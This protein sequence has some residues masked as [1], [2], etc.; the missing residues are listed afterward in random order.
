MSFQTT[1]APSAARRHGMKQSHKWA[2]GRSLRK[3]PLL[4][5]CSSR[6]PGDMPVCSISPRNTQAVLCTGDA[7]AATGVGLSVS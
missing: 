3:M 1:S 6:A 2:L 5:K 4:G 7:A